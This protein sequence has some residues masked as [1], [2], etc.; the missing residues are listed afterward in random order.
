M[1]VEQLR[2][3]L[4][5]LCKLGR[6]HL[7]ARVAITTSTKWENH[8]GTVDDETGMEFQE[9]VEVSESNGIGGPY[10]IIEGDR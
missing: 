7:P 8:D 10:L 4:D 1:T 5:R 2:D 6:G 3:E 9:L